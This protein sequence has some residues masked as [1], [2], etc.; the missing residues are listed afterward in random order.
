MIKSSK[1]YDQ[2]NLHANGCSCCN[3]KQERRTVK[4]ATK[5]R[6]ETRWRRETQDEKRGGSDA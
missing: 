4:K 5:R 1:D 2:K 6:E 3:T